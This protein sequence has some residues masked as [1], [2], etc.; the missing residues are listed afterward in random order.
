[1]KLLACA[2]PFGLLLAASPVLAGRSAVTTIGLTG[3]MRALGKT[4]DSTVNAEAKPLAGLR[5]T[6][7]FEEDPL[8]IPDDPFVAKDFRVVPELLAGFLSDDV[9]AEGYVGAG[10]RAEVQIANGHR[11]DRMA[12]YTAARGIVIGK[13]R[14]GATELVLGGY[15]FLPGGERFGWEGGAMARPRPN[16]APSEARE[17]DAELT[18]YVGWRL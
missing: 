1:M 9:R 6:L 5:L 14:D 7:G 12:I 11:R 15:V 10:V 4:Y 18:F 2:L 16:A 8:A 17:L 3:D 13:D